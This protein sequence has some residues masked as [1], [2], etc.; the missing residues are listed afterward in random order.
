MLVTLRHPTR[1]VEVDGPCRV[2]VLLKRLEFNRESV[3]VIA[4]GAIVPG[5]AKLQDTDVVELSLIHI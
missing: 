2:D 3:L 4:N 5:D 1:E